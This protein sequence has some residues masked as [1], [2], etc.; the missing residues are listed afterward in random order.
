MNIAILVHVSIYRYLYCI[1][2]Y[3]ITTKQSIAYIDMSFIFLT[4][5]YVMKI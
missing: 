2:N 1:D 3:D 4:L 5:M